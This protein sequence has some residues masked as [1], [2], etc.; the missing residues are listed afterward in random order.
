VIFTSSYFQY[1]LYLIVCFNFCRIKVKSLIFF[2][3]LLT[4]SFIFT[5]CS[6]SGVTTAPICKF[7]RKS[8]W[9]CIVDTP[10]RFFLQKKKKQNLLK[11][12][13]PL[14]Y[15]DS[16]ILVFYVFILVKLPIQINK[17]KFYKLKMNDSLFTDIF[18]SKH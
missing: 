3:L 18:L 17:Y 8:G 14:F 5:F 2:Y 9:I 11:T 15:V 13:T 4:I 10:C 7:S 6:I 1:H 16:K 12:P